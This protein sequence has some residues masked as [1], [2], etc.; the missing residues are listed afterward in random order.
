MKQKRTSAA[1]PTPIKVVVVTLDNHLN[2]VMREA[3]GELS[4]KLPG[5]TLRMHA[6]TNWDAD[7]GALDE[8]LA[9]IATGDIILVTM[10]FMEHQINAVL[11]ALAARRD[12]CDA[13]IC[14]MSAAEVMKLTRMGRFSMDGEVSGPMALLKRLRGKSSG[15]K[16][17]AGAQQV[18]VLRQLPRI[19]RFIPGTAQDVRAYFLTLQYWLAASEENICE[20][21]AFLVDRYAAGSRASLKGSLRVQSPVE[22]PETGVY[23]PKM[24]G[25]ISAKASAL[26]RRRNGKAG[27]VGLL[28]M[29]SYALAG[30][31]A[32]YDAVIAGLEARGFSVI[33]AFAS[34]LDARPAVENFFLK[35]GEVMVDAVV[36]LTGFSLVGGPAYNDAD[37]AQELLAS[38][39]VPYLSAQSLEFQS[40]DRWQESEQGLTPIE[41][42]MM[43]AIPELEGATGPIIFGGRGSDGAEDMTPH[44]ERIETLVSR[45][46]RLVQLRKRARAERKL[47]IVL[48][49]FPP[50]G[51]N[52]GTAAHLSVFASLYNTLE[53]LAREGYTIDLPASVDALREA[54][55]DGNSAQH[56]VHANVHDYVDV[57]DHLRRE[58]WLAELEAQWQAPLHSRGAVWQRIRRRA[59][60]LWLGG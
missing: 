45:V 23:H 13:M 30:N 28:I 10:L 22:Y 58:P 40:M 55:V 27:T 32:H 5:L 26:P 41:A 38:L 50:N 47:A 25:R 56:G 39:D 51:G 29:R 53:M 54:I 46:E 34:G 24:K 37:A 33:T 11:P 4:R 52:T 17:G 44:G 20:L 19:L 8:C 12:D 14:C 2:S 49:N 43:V 15:S 36:S 16:S 35:D 7:Q 18:S 48:F 57:D 59:A 6:A 1:D 60:L 9:D 42:T 3:E 21:V 31:T